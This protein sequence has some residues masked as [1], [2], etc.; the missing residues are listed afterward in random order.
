M[1]ANGIR[2]ITEAKSPRTT[3][4]GPVGD[5]P[6]DLVRRAFHAD[7]PNQLWVADIT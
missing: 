2:G 4:P 7:G 6:E 3:I 5:R 1:R